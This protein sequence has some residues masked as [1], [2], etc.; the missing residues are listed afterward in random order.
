MLQL[1]V[2][3][4]DLIFDVL[5]YPD[6]PRLRDRVSHGE[7][8]IEDLPREVVDQVFFVCAVLCIRCIASDSPL[9]EVNR[10]FYIKR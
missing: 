1:L 3:P 10:I 7:S 4:Q 2:N 6:G 9:H 8:N 5:A